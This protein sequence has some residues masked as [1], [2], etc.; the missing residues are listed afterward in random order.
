MPE[1]DFTIIPKV[2][3]PFADLERA[4]LLEALALGER[5]LEEGRILTQAQARR[6]MSR[7]FVPDPNEPVPNYV[8]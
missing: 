6:R 2:P 1:L 3:R 4:Q 8:P 7:W 5:A